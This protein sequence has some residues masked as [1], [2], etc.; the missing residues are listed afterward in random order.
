MPNNSLVVIDNI[1]GKNHDI[2]LALDNTYVI[3]MYT[4]ELSVE[5]GKYGFNIMPQSVQVRE[6]SA[7]RDLDGLFIDVYM[8]YDMEADDKYSVAWT[9]FMAKA[10]AIM[11]VLYDKQNLITGVS[12]VSINVGFDNPIVEKERIIDLTYQCEYKIFA[13]R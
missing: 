7:E 3:S 6:L 10:K 4:P 5:R 9:K 11:D 2:I 8:H 12:T 13:S 1:I